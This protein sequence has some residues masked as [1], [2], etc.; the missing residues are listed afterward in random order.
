MAAPPAQHLVQGPILFDRK[1]K[2][3]RSIFVE[4]VKLDEYQYEHDLYS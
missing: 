1:L 4:L 3:G 2:I